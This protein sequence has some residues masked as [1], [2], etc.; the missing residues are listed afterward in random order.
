MWG[1]S[2]I[3]LRSSGN[4]NAGTLNGSPLPTWNTSG[5]F[6]GDLVFHGDAAATNVTI[7]NPAA[8]QITTS[9]TVT[10]WINPTS[11]NSSDEDDVIVT[12][13]NST[14]WEYTF[15]GSQDCSGVNLQ[16]NLLLAFTPDGTT[17]QA[18]CS[19]SV[20]QTNTWTFV[21]GVYNSVAQTVDVY[22][23]GVL[24]DGPWYGGLSTV[25]T[26]L[27]N[28]TAPVLIGGNVTGG[29]RWNGTIDDARIYNRALSASEIATLAHP[30]G[31][32]FYNSAYNV[33]Q[34]CN[35]INWVRI[36]M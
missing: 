23:N 34:Y 35:G 36:G 2:L 30:E 5:M 13:A 22:V 17:Y 27:Y 4:N 11:I 7:G 9:F 6:N 19:N 20:L 14:D 33:M 18:R 24:D 21:A 1:G 29:Q 26:V 15:K 31:D 12:K 8:L 25:P 3:H 10:A 28:S 32:M 16:D